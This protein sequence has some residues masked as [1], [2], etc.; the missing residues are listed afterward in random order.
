MQL[1]I[2]IGF[3][4]GE[5]LYLHQSSHSCVMHDSVVVVVVNTLIFSHPIIPLKLTGRIR[6]EVKVD[7]C[8]FESHG[9]LL[10]V[11][12]MGVRI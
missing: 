3:I 9:I 7:C 4:P 12:V 1:V 2:D 8:K 6:V 10:H 5:C 11:H